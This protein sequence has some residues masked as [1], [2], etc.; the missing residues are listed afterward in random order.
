VESHYHFLLVAVDAPTSASSKIPR[1]QLDRVNV[2]VGHIHVS[3]LSDRS[4]IAAI[5]PVA[6]V[7][8]FVAAPWNEWEGS[9]EAGH[10]SEFRREVGYVFDDQVDDTAGTLDL[11]TAAEH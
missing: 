2:Q 6:A 11:A 10:S 7:F 5:G 8:G 4:R 9:V 3:R 1:L